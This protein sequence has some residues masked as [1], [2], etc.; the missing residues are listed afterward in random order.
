MTKEEF[1]EEIIKEHKLACITAK[2]SYCMRS[3]IDRYFKILMDNLFE[4]VEIEFTKKQ[5]TEGQSSPEQ[6]S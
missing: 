5:P 2:A 6:N 3:K 1:K 4:E